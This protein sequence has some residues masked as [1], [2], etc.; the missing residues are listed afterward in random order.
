MS[1]DS[2]ILNVNRKSRSNIQVIESWLPADYTKPI[3][4]TIQNHIIN[5]VYNTYHVD[6]INVFYRE[7]AIFASVIPGEVMR[8]SIG[9][10]IQFPSWLGKNSTTNKNDRLIQELSHHTCLKWVCK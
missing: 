9:Q 6:Q 4:R 5:R 7:Q 8:G 2:K 10:M 1:P 3:F